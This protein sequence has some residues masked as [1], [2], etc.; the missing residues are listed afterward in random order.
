MAAVVAAVVVAATSAVAWHLVRQS[1]KL[2]NTGD[3][4]HSTD[5]YGTYDDGMPPAD[6]RFVGEWQNADNPS[7]H[8]VYY[9]D[10]EADGYYWGKEWHEDEN[11]EEEDLVFHGNGWF[12]WKVEDKMLRELHCMDGSD[13]KVPKSYRSEFSGRGELILTDKKFKDTVFRFRRQE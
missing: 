7:W 2:H 4:T 9:D 10:Y 5:V 11:I 8:R 3:I 6:K 1:E 12:L 13:V